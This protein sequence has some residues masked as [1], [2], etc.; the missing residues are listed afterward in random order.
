MGDPADRSSDWLRLCVGPLCSSAAG[1]NGKCLPAKAFNPTNLS[2]DQWVRTARDMGAGE[3]CLT[4]H[5]EVSALSVS[6]VSSVSAA[7]ATPS[8]HG[9]LRVGHTGRILPLAN[10]VPELFCREFWAVGTW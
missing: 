1:V 4:A 8:Q 7:C 10:R 3:I 5:H 9:A 6:S 2:T